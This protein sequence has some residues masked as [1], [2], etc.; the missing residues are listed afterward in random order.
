MLES[1][2]IL[3]LYAFRSWHVSSN[4]DK[5]C[6]CPLYVCLSLEKNRSLWSYPDL[7]WHAHCLPDSDLDFVVLIFAK[8]FIQPMEPCEN[9]CRES[10]LHS[11]KINFMDRLVGRTIDEKLDNYCHI[12]C[13]KLLRIR[14]IKR[15]GRWGFVPVFGMAEVFSSTIALASLFINT[16]HYRRSIRHKLS[17]SPMRC[18][19]S[20]QHLI[21]N[22][23]FMSSCLF[24]ARETPFTRYADYFTA[25]AS[26]M[27]GF[28][29]PMNRLVLLYY[30]KSFRKFSKITLRI[31][32]SYFVFH[33]LKMAC[34]EFDYT[35]NKISCAL[36]FFV[37]CICNF[38]M[39][40]NYRREPH[41]KNI[42]Y[43]VGCL[44]V[45]GGVEILDISPL[46]YLFDSHALWHLLMAVATPY[47]I[48]FISKDIDFHSSKEKKNK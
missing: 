4:M 41:A 9:R 40:L 47:Y 15:K 38:I 27:L 35:Y 7:A 20:L 3:D 43:S 26:I 32:V 19:Y 37:S 13:L 28:L 33:V 45:A 25:F 31:G 30:P 48:E 22:A 1:N 18:L 11:V 46:F 5:K 23:A 34:H 17:R 42:V 2:L 24:H 16:Y 29:V 36:M 6:R 44:L 39:F 12:D 8:Q 21:C 10:A 14:N